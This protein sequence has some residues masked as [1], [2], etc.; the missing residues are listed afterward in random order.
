MLRRGRSHL[1]GERVWCRINWRSN[2]LVE[3]DVDLEALGRKLG[4]LAAYE[5]LAD[6]D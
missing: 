3:E 6:D 1:G 2:W 5:T 4:A